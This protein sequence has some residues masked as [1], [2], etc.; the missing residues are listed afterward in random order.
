MSSLRWWSHNSRVFFGW[1]SCV[2]PMKA[3]NTIQMWGLCQV[4]FLHIICHRPF[5]H[6]VCGGHRATGKW[7]HFDWV[8]HI[9][10]IDINACN[11]LLAGAKNLLSVDKWNSSLNLADI[12]LRMTWKM[13]RGSCCSPLVLWGGSNRICMLSCSCKYYIIKQDFCLIL[14]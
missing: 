2:S 6:A 10:E 9:L 11:A 3:L 4:S 7:W 5:W 12:K 1:P 13:V 8:S 14:I